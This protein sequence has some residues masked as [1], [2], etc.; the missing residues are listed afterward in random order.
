MLLSNQK[1][2]ELYGVEGA[3][4]Y[5][6]WLSHH[7]MV[8]SRKLVEAYPMNKCGTKAEEAWLGAAKGFLICA[9]EFIKVIQ[10]LENQV[11]ELQ[12]EVA[13]L[14]GEPVNVRKIIDKSTEKH[15]SIAKPKKGFKVWL[16]RLVNKWL[17]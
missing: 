2:Q 10:R 7:D 14:K 4:F 13:I 11:I 12:T 15:L 17:D 8:E 1:R 5:Q 6:L 9:E 16:K 3:K